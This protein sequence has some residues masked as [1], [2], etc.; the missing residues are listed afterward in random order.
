MTRV[1]YHSDLKK[2]HIGDFMLI[3][4]QDKLTK[5]ARWCYLLLGYLVRFFFL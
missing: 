1:V 4:S 3:M 5:K 2:K